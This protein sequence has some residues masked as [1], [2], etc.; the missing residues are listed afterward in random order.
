MLPGK[1][2][3]HF[4]K[5]AF[6]QNRDSYLKFCKL[7]LFDSNTPSRYIWGNSLLFLLNVNKKKFKEG[8]ALLLIKRLKLAIIFLLFYHFLTATFVNRFT[9]IHHISDLLYLWRQYHVDKGYS[10]SNYTILRTQHY[11]YSNDYQDK[12]D[13][14]RLWGLS[15]CVWK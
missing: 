6:I 14:E 4:W 13:I 15:Y 12:N 5:L 11:F 8:V 7:I 10:E 2:K 9:H 1:K 3:Q